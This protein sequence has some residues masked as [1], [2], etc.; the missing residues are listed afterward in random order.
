M[1]FENVS[2]TETSM[3]S[4]S[5]QVRSQIVMILILELTLSSLAIL[6]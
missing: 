6:P 3:P 5:N 1:A 2:L 4:L